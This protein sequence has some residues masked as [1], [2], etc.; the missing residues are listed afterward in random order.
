MTTVLEPIHDHPPDPAPPGVRRRILEFD[1]LDRIGTRIADIAGVQPA[2][3]P[4]GAPRLDAD[5]L[6][7][8]GG[9][10]VRNPWKHPVL[11][12]FAAAV[13]V[14]SVTAFALLVTGRLDDVYEVVWRRIPGRQWTHVMRDHPWI[15]VG[16]AVPLAAVPYALAPPQR[17]GRAFLTYVIFLIGFLGGHVF[18]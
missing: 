7:R 3:P 6:K 8:A 16:L 4:A 2:R 11:L 12:A 14:F 5:L 17:W 18:W 15:Y 13:A 1:L 10:I 9:A